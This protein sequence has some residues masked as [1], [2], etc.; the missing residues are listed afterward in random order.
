MLISQTQEELKTASALIAKCELKRVRLHRCVAS[1]E[2]EP[3]T[4]NQPF[5]LRALYNSTAGEIVDQRL[6]VQVQFGFESFDASTEEIVLFK[7]D[8]WFDL[9]YELEAKYQ[10]SAEAVEAFKNGN[11]IFNCWPYA[12]ECVQSITARMALQPPPLPLLRI[13]PKKPTTKPETTVPASQVPTT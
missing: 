4:L 6:P 12:R 11:A 13:A 8:C 1:L 7:I 9:D 5:K 2:A 3:E 10:P